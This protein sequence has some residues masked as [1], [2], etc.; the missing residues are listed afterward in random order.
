[1]RV[2][3]LYHSWKEFLFLHHL[4]CICKHLCA[5]HENILSLGALRSA[6]AADNYKIS[7]QR[8]IVASAEREGKGLIVGERRTQVGC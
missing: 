8:P 3:L 7:H 4:P 1:M 6:G 5:R 2:G